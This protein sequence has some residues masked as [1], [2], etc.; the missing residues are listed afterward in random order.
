MFGIDNSVLLLIVLLGLLVLGLLAFGTGS[1]G[2]ASLEPIK[3]PLCIDGCSNYYKCYAA[4]DATDLSGGII[5]YCYTDKLGRTGTSD[6]QSCNRCKYCQ[7]CPGTST[8]SGMCISV[9]EKCPDGKPSLKAPYVTSSYS[10]LSIFDFT[11]LWGKYKQP[12]MDACGANISIWSSL[13]DGLANLNYLNA[14]MPDGSGDSSGSRSGRFG[15]W[16]FSL[17]SSSGG[18]NNDENDNNDNNNTSNDCC[19]EEC[20]EEEEE[21]W[22]EYTSE[23]HKIADAQQE[24]MSSMR[25]AK[26]AIRNALI[27]KLGT[28]TAMQSFYSGSSTTEGFSSCTKQGKELQNQRINMNEYIRK[29]SIPC[30]GCSV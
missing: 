8:R 11:R 28:T 27:D 23:Q 6:E 29:D 7:Y 3:D 14:G 15:R 5:D 4:K 22:P 9:F 1:E 13:N 24:R 2:F 17:P 20:E 26:D 10:W 25:T 18:D 19:E 12:A 21:E 16:V 30:W